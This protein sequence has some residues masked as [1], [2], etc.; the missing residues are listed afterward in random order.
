MTIPSYLSFDP[1]RQSSQA[2]SVKA[3]VT[4]ITSLPSSQGLSTGVSSSTSVNLPRVQTQTVTT[5]ISRNSGSS[6]TITSLYDN[7][8]IQQAY[9]KQSIDSQSQQ[10]KTLYN[11]YTN[12]SN[13]KQIQSYALNE[14]ITRGYTNPNDSEVKQNLAARKVLTQIEQE[15]LNNPDRQFLES[16]TGQN[17]T[18][19]L[20]SHNRAVSQ[21]DKD[22]AAF[23][24]QN[25]KYYKNGEYVNL[26]GNELSRL[27]SL[28]QQSKTLN[29][30]EFN[31]V[32]SA[33]QRY[34]QK[35]KDYWNYQQENALAQKFVGVELSKAQ[36][37]YKKSDLYT[38][39]GREAI[40]QELPN[41]K[42]KSNMLTFGSSDNYIM[43]SFNKKFDA[44]TL[45]VDQAE[46]VIPQGIKNSILEKKMPIVELIEMAPNKISVYDAPEINIAGVKN[47]SVGILNGIR[48]RIVEHPLMLT[49]EYA[50]FKTLGATFESASAATSSWNPV[51]TISAKKVGG[52]ALATAYGV[53]VYGKVSSKPLGSVEQ[54]QV[55]G[56]E[57]VDFGVMW[58]GASSGKS[59]IEKN[60]PSTA[61]KASSSPTLNFLKTYSK[62][63]ASYTESSP[64]MIKGVNFFE[65]NNPRTQ[66]G[67]VFANLEFGGG[68][69]MKFSKGSGGSIPTRYGAYSPAGVSETR[70][71]TNSIKDFFTSDQNKV[72]KAYSSAYDA[73]IN[74]GFKDK[75]YTN[76]VR[77]TGFTTM[78]S[79]QSSAFF[80]AFKFFRGGAAYRN[81]IQK[82]SK[83]T[84]GDIDIDLTWSD[85]LTDKLASTVQKANLLSKKYQLEKTG[86]N[87][88]QS[89]KNVGGKR[90]VMGIAID[91]K[92]PWERFT[93]SIT[94]FGELQPY[95]YGIPIWDAWLKSKSP[96]GKT[97]YLQSLSSTFPQVGQDVA[98]RTKARLGEKPSVTFETLGQKPIEKRF[99]KLDKMSQ[100]FGLKDNF[101]FDFVK[102]KKVVNSPKAKMIILSGKSSSSKSSDN[103]DFI[104]DIKSKSLSST[105][106]SLL[107]SQSRP[108]SKS[109]SSEFSSFFSGLSSSKSSESSKSSSSSPTSS[110]SSGSSSSSPSSFSNIPPSFFIAAPQ[111]LPSGQL[112]GGWSGKGKKGRK[113]TGYAPSFEAF[114]LG[115][116]AKKVPKQ[117]MFTG[118]ELR[119]VII[120]QGGRVKW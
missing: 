24:Q 106:S 41:A 26:P 43:A 38:S 66:T 29:N 49:A 76:T 60:F 34:T 67:S 68:Q 118:Q 77:T 21:L 117:S 97:I 80:D 40:L 37:A 46:K 95:T 103:S 50:G 55:I 79:K 98:I 94:P 48:E 101:K 59:F 92:T 104:S 74:R 91:A 3:P 57:L 65:Y 58:A 108:S 87:T 47:E 7:P 28:N 17:R 39:K 64:E 22:F 73:I 10:N 119:P 15:R 1:A 63:A 32:T 112:G 78:T 13:I 18:E 54:G 89:V 42:Q 75:T 27:E 45:G 8:V 113:K 52:A 20:Y 33:S 12:P 62:R 35:F 114:L 83:M 96:S 61:G 105:S 23:S 84:T 25:K 5:Q 36:T 111:K 31:D 109:S 6:G 9:G 70:T 110:R 72:T 69:S 30:Q 11:Y 2:R 51:L 16:S 82:S 102:E 44:F 107:E 71:Y 88:Y 120:G 19:E 14:A 4:T 85:V 115:I 81:Q 116:T 100:E 56:G 53:N 93:Q 90:E 86:P 99:E